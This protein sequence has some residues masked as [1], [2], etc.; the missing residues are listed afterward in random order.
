MKKTWGLIAAVMIVIGG[1]SFAGARWMA[2][3]HRPAT[4]ANLRDNAWL[5]RELKLSAAQAEAIGKLESGLRTE[6]D[7]ACGAHCAARMALGNELMKPQPDLPKCQACVEKMNAAQA[8]A[9]RVT[10]AHI[11][12]VRALLDAGQAQRYCT[13]IRDQVCNMPMGTP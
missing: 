5:K 12:K 8:T 2:C 1:L 10:L 4:A 6:L 11:L 3:H 13:I 7:G 9:E